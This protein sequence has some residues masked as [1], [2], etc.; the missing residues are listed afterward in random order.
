MFKTRLI[1]MPVERIAAV[2]FHESKAVTDPPG[3]I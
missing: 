3:S 1:T 2:F